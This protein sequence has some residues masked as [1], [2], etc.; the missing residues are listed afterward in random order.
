[1]ATPAFYEYEVSQ[2]YDRHGNIHATIEHNVCKINRNDM[3]LYIVHEW[4]L[5]KW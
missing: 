1:M 4:T 3:L 5:F 2:L